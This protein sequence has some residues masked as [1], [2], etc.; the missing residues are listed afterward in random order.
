ME[1]FVNVLTGEKYIKIDNAFYKAVSVENLD[2]VCTDKIY[3]HTERVTNDKSI[4]EILTTKFNLKDSIF[5]PVNGRMIEFVVEH[6]ESG[7]FSS[8]VTF[9]SKDIIDRIA[10]TNIEDYLDDF[11]KWM[12][13]DLLN[14]MIWREH[15]RY[16][17]A[18][19]RRIGLLSVGNIGNL[20]GVKPITF[21]TGEN[22]NTYD[23]IKNKVDLCKRYKGE[24]L[25]WWTDSGDKPEDNTR[26]ITSD[27]RFICIGRD[28]SIKAITSFAN[29]IKGVVLCFSIAQ[30]TVDY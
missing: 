6:I 17:Y 20:D 7:D 10:M 28:G 18:T 13:K 29:C 12:P 4:G 16:G 14:A 15:I 26:N 8:I 23:G 3:K 27:M 22:D 9:V 24:P 30:L 21:N 19:R 25:E 5:V 11:R 2:L 1:N